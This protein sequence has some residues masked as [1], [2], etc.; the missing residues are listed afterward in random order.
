MNEDFDFIAHLIYNTFDEGGRSS[1]AKSGYRPHIKFDFDE[2]LT[3]GSQIF[4]DKEWVFP[5]ETVDAEITIL[6]PQ[7]FENK[8]FKGLEFKFMEGSNLIGI[9]KILDIKNKILIKK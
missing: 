2:V 8:L 3:S 1:P 7:L 4:I 6:S 5:G 9:G